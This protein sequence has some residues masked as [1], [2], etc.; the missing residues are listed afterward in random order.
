MPL[1]PRDEF[2]K[3]LIERRKRIGLTQELLSNTIRNR[4]GSDISVI[5]ISRIK[6]GKLNSKHETLQQIENVICEYEEVF[7]NKIKPEIGEKTANVNR[8]NRDS[9]NKLRSKRP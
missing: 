8:D 6:R 5:T 1:K 3:E 2:I 9:I 4:F 7:K